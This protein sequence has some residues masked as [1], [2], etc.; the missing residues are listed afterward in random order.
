MLKMIQ[1]LKENNEV[2][3]LLKQNRVSLVGVTQNEQK[4][5]MQA[6]IEKNSKGKGI[7]A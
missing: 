7:W 1:F 3:E 5:I 6:F 4:A 2:L